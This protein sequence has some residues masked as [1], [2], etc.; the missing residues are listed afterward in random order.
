MFNL[1]LIHSHLFS[2]PSVHLEKLYSYSAV[3]IDIVD[4]GAI[5]L[6]VELTAER[7]DQLHNRPDSYI[8]INEE[9]GPT[10]AYFC[11]FGCGL[12]RLTGAIGTFN[13]QRKLDW[14]P[15][16]SRP[17]RRNAFASEVFLIH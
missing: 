1:D 5:H 15:R 8:H 6:G 11:G 16:T 4:P 10:P 17:L 12:K 9:S 3:A 7:R 13:F 14:N 2:K